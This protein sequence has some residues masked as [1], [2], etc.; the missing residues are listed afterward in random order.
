MLG[1]R[2]PQ[3]GHAVGPEPAYSCREGNAYAGG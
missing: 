3:D 1:T 2:P